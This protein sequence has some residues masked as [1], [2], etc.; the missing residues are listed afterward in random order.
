M[1]TQKLLEELKA[2]GFSQ[3][4]IARHVGCSP[5]YLSMIRSGRRGKRPGHKLVMRLLE[6]RDAPLSER[7]T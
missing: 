1:E 5:N 7:A 4:E 6:L 3:V 2:R